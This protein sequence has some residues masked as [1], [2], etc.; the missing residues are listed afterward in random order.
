M[1]KML[2]SCSYFG[3]SYRQV[4]ILENEMSPKMQKNQSKNGW[5]C[6]NLSNPRNYPTFGLNMGFFCKILSV[7]RNIVMNVRGASH[8]GRRSRCHWFPPIKL[9]EAKSLASRPFTLWP[10]S[11]GCRNFKWLLF[12]EGDGLLKEVWVVRE[13]KPKLWSRGRREAVERPSRGRRFFSLNNKSLTRS[14]PLDWRGCFE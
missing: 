14:W 9:Q 12:E 10:K 4:T 2:D 3:S 6:T 1:A 7:P 11:K 8:Y 13:W 5:R